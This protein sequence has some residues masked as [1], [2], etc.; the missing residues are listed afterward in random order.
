MDT[1]VPLDTPATLAVAAVRPVKEQVRAAIVD[2]CVEVGK[3]YGMRV[4]CCCGL[5]RLLY[6][7][8]SRKSSPATRRIFYATWALAI[9]P[10]KSRKL[11]PN[12]WSYF[13]QTPGCGHT[14]GTASEP[15]SVRQGA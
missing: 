2:R 9:R 15:V 4:R 14:I 11:A 3:K 10:K 13:F 12:F 8:P 5:R 1:L 7:A 6:P